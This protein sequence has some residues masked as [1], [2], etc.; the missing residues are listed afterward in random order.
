[1]PSYASAKVEFSPDP[2]SDVTPTWIDVSRFIQVVSW[3]SGKAKDLDDPTAGGASILLEN[4][5]RRFEPEYVAGAYYPNIVPLRRFRISLVTSAGTTRQGIYYVT[6]WKPAYPTGQQYSTVTAECVDGF[7]ILSLTPLPAMDPPSAASLA[8]V[9]AADEPYAHYRL[10]DQA[11]TKMTA[12]VGQDGTYVNFS[13]TGGVVSN[14]LPALVVGE[15][16]TALRFTRDAGSPALARGFGR[17]PIQD[18]NRFGDVNAFTVEAVMSIEAVG[19][20][21]FIASGPINAGLGNTIFDLIADPTNGTLQLVIR[22]AAGTTFAVTTINGTIAPDT[23][24]H[25]AA[26]WDGHTAWIYVNGLPATGTN[27]GGF[28]MAN[29][30]AT[31][32]VYVSGAANQGELRLQDVAFYEVALSAARVKAHADAARLRGRAAE[33]AGDRIAALAANPL[34]STAGIAASDLTTAPVMFAGQVALDAIVTAAQSERP[35]GVFFFDDQGNPDYVG[36]NDDTVTNVAAVFGDLGGELRY[37]DID[38]T[39][40]DELY[41][42]VVTSREEGANQTVSDLASQ[43]QFYVRGIEETG[44][45]V[46]TDTDAARVGQAIL[47]NFS[48]PMFRVESITVNGAQPG[49]LTQILTREIGDVVRVRRRGEGLTPIDITT[50]ILG[51]SKSIDTNGNVVCT[52]ALARGFNSSS[53]VWRLGI[54]G[55]DE[56]GQTTVLA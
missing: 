8:D 43:D 19:V 4:D 30:S 44:L 31:D 49:V 21:S 13:L 24:Y 22:N 42:Q 50:T 29:G 3:G 48:N 53:P 51:K 28:V 17:G 41:N 10:G 2:L 25:V 46:N 5:A 55:Y 16:A 18:A 15:S 32:F 11:G 12:A 26:T 38:L 7:G 27:R 40:D 20:G 54:N 52:W 6:S 37:Q 33:S 36:W 47:D 1:M 35:F 45:A 34:W 14:I 23:V 39:Y 56:L 9:Y